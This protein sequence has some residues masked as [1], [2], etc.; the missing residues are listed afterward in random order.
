MMNEKLSAEHFNFKQFTLKISKGVF[1]VTTDSVL[2][3]S[4]VNV[5]NAKVILDL[6]CGSGIISLMLAQKSDA[7]VYAVDVDLLSIECAKE[8]VQNSPW[9]DK[10]HV[11][12]IELQELQ[13][14]EIFK[15]YKSN[16]DLVVSNPPYFQQ[17]LLSA[18]E[19]MIRSK[20]QH[21]FDFETLAEVSDYYLTEKGKAC[22]VIPLKSE[23]HLSF[24]MYLHAFQLNKIT[25]IKHRQ[26]SEFSLALVEYRR[27]LDR[28]EQNE[29][30]LYNHDG[31]KT[32]EFVE[33]TGAY[34]I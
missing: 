4:W 7:T 6:G 11:L 29:I 19:H 17:Q 24:Q 25:K 10:I 16:V 20:H 22:F 21:K 34:Y 30:V 13:V 33:L 8:N 15:A 28:F 32:E 12:N 2:L 31:S 18:E 1:P 14:L 23:T 3:G 5:G 27:L 9:K 26:T